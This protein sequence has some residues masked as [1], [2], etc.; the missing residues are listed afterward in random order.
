MRHILLSFVILL[1]F[2]PAISGQAD[3]LVNGQSA[4]VPSVNKLSIRFQ[5]GTY[6]SL[7]PGYGTTYGAF[8]GP[9][10]Y[11]PVSK[12]FFLSGGIM[13]SSGIY[14]KIPFNTEYHLQ[15]NPSQTSF[16]LYST[17]GYHASES[18][19]FYG[20]GIYRINNLPVPHDQ[21]KLSF[22]EYELGTIFRLGRNVTFQ[23]SF[24]FSDH[25]NNYLF[26]PGYPGFNFPPFY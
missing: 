7:M 20:T 16:N 26:A 6:M 11:Y 12:R 10:L 8:G 23:A 15:N 21:L 9:V 1:L 22:N 4:P 24:R 25:K 2:A 17:A 13:A 5:A 18:L 19:T 14:R 3:T